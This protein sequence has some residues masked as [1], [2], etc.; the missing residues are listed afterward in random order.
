MKTASDYLRLP[1]ERV[2]LPEEESGTF[3]ALMRELPG[4]VAQGD[5]PAEAYVHLDAA[6]E[7]WIEAALELGQEIPTPDENQS[8]SGRVLVRL[9][10]SVH[11]RA[12]EAARRDG[13]SLNQFIL[14]AVA[15]RLGATRVQSTVPMEV[16]PAGEN[17]RRVQRPPRSS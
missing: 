8:Y 4:C 11:R 15:E 7:S 16:G 5:T 10:R 2:L 13:T 1:Y 6:A 9:P 14:A 17:R 3:T 12:T